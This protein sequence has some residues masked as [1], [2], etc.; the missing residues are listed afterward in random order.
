MTALRVSAV[1]IIVFI[2]DLDIDFLRFDR[3]KM[4]GKTREL[5]SFDI[6]TVE[7]KIISTNGL[8]SL[9]Y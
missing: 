3:K 1:F 9:S 8:S 5:I 7:N 6:S 2:E 4:V